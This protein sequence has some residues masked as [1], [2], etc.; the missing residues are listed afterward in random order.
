MN[1]YLFSKKYIKHLFEAH[2]SGKRG[3][4]SQLWTLLVLAE[5]YAQHFENTSLEPED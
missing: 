1:K 4:G 5:W 3:Y 2:R